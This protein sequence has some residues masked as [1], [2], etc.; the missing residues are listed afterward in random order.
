MPAANWTIYIEE[1]SQFDLYAYKFDSECS[2]QSLSGYG[3]KFQ[4]RTTR[5]ATG[6]VLYEATVGSGLYI[7]PGSETGLVQVL[8]TVT[9][10]NAPAE[11]WEKAFYDLLVWP[12][13]GS[14]TSG[15][16][17]ILEGVAYWKPSATRP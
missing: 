7:E 9:V 16:K 8:L 11:T 12:G 6:V 13:T 1:G 10:V 5:A 14:I 17:R 3:A 15:A 2:A 4:I